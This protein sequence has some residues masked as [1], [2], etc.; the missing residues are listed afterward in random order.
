MG[1]ICLSPSVA[2][3]EI[4]QAKYLLLVRVRNGVATWQQNICSSEELETPCMPITRMVYKHIVHDY[5]A[6]KG[7]TLEL[8][9]SAE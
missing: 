7:D 9:A 6:L 4:M 5:T 8:H 2:R 3:G 1:K